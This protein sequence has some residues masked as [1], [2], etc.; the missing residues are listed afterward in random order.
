MPRYDTNP[1][2]EDGRSARQLEGSTSTVLVPNS[3]AANYLNDNFGKDL[4][5]LWRKRAGDE[6]A[7]LQV[8]TDLISTESSISPAPPDMD[9]V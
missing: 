4:I 8:S 6:D 2:F 1:V 3:T 5:F 7:V 9:V